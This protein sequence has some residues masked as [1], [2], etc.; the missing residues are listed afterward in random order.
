MEFAASL[1]AWMATLSAGEL[2]SK[3]LLNSLSAREAWSL[4]MNPM[5]NNALRMAPAATLI[6]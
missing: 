3:Q 2:F 4:G 1:Q 5:K 6:A